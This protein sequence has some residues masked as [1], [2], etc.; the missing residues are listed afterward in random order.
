MDVWM[1]DA[2]GGWMKRLTKRRLVLGLAGLLMIV[3]FGV[4]V[5][6]SANDSCAGADTPY[7]NSELKT[8]NFSGFINPSIAADF[9]AGASNNAPT[10]AQ[11]NAYDSLI[12]SSGDRVP[13][14]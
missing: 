3:G 9:G 12:V 1:E 2:G 8:Y 11:R 7:C 10:L 5:P 13:G 6:V 4:S 14:R